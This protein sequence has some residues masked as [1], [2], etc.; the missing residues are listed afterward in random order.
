VEVRVVEQ[1]TWGQQ[2]KG[3]QATYPDGYVRCDV[4]VQ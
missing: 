4:E 3:T 1:L 2:D